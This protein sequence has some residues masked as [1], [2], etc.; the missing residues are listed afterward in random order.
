[1]TSESVWQ[2]ARSWVDVGSFHTRLFGVVY[3]AITSFREFLDTPSY[4]WNYS[5]VKLYACDFDVTVEKALRCLVTVCTQRS[6]SSSS[7]QS[8]PNSLYPTKLPRAVSLIYS[9]RWIPLRV[10]NSFQNCLERRM[11]SVP[12]V[13]NSKPDCHYWTDQCSIRE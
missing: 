8:V 9:S 4:I 12:C 11:V 2:V 7:S 3:F 13:C 5:T 6:P 1:M 10:T